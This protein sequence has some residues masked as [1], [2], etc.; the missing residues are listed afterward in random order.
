[1]GIEP[2]YIELHRAKD[3]MRLLKEIRDFRASCEQTL[4]EQTKR[5]SELYDRIDRILEYLASSP[6]KQG[7]SNE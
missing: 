4:I 1:M 6:L 2:F 7:G 3:I 5:C